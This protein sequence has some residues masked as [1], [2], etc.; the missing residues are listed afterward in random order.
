MELGHPYTGQ[1]P[2]LN[3]QGNGL[4]QQQHE[5]DDHGFEQLPN[6]HLSQAI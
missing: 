1:S 6:V 3:V 5:E 4:Q 2:P